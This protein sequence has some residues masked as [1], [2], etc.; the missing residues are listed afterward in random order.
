[1]ANVDARRKL[2]RNQFYL[3]LMSCAIA[4]TLTVF[5]GFVMFAQP[6]HVDVVIPSVPRFRYYGWY[7]VIPFAAAPV[8]LL[9]VALALA[10]PLAGFI[11]VVALILVGASAAWLVGLWIVS[12][13]HIAT[14]NDP[15][16]PTNPANSYY[17]CCTAPFFTA[18]ASC[19][20]F[21]N[22]SP[23]C[24]PPRV[25][26]DLGANGDAVMVIIVELLMCAFYAVVFVLLLQMGVLLDR[27][28]RGNK[29]DED[30]IATAASAPP[31]TN[32][33]NMKAPLIQSQNAGTSLFIK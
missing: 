21:G 17:A 6:V 26:A 27:L 1:M 28:R 29:L 4:L 2:E 22:P 12:A 8:V 31:T 11:R 14:K 9:I 25:L 24:F 5:L 16:N 15:A 33:D 18:V 32:T 23:Q 3:M 10:F 13:I 30:D 20:N 19:P 7:K